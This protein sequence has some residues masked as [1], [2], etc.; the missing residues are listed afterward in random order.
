MPTSS[1]Q[2]P[3]T[4]VPRRTQ[5]AG[6][7]R[8]AAGNSWTGRLA[9]FGMIVRGVIYFVP[10]ALA[11][12]MAMGQQHASMTQQGAIE[13]IGQQPFGRLL[14]IVVAVG[15]GGYAIWGVVRSVFDP[16][17]RG[18]TPIG[19]VQRTGYLIS[20]LAYAG[21][22]AATLRYFADS[23]AH[24][25]PQDWTAS[26]LARPFGAVVVAVVGLCW[27]F[28]SGL[29]QIVQ[30]W[31]GSFER[32]LDL[33]RMSRAEEQLAR[34]LG[35]IGLV[36]RGIVFTVIGVLLLAA[37]ARARPHLD[38]GLDGALMQIL[39][40]PF[41]RLLLGAAG[42]GLM[43]FGCYSAMCARWLRIPHAASGSSVP[44]RP[45]PL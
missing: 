39:H 20:A 45:S 28:G 29:M 38:V 10:G 4:L 11:L 35:R 21:L 3:I 37:A 25:V 43:A 17:D 14:L 9:R 13:M 19:I 1:P 24:L 26:L 30:G 34:R 40:Q 6:L 18:H 12:R 23:R 33:A 27:I 36:S 44:F 15:L 7:A 16:M 31:K 2:Q 32:D 42:I 5:A 8:A 22:F 41:G